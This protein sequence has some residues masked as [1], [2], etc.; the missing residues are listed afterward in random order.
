MIRLLTLVTANLDTMMM[1]LLNARSVTIHVV[2]VMVIA[3][4]AL[5]ALLN[6]T[7]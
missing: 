1:P 7:D 4:F 6:V 5:N 3:Y 2:N